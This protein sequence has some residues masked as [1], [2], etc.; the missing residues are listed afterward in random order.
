MA[1]PMLTAVTSVMRTMQRILLETPRL[2]LLKGHVITV[3]QG[4]TIVRGPQ[5]MQ[6][7]PVISAEQTL[8]ALTAERA[9]FVI[10][11]GQ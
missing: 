5:G 2:V 3:L 1:I 7:P 9:A 8:A 4:I 11:A 6:L 10:R